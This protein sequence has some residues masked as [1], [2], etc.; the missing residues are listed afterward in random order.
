MQFTIFYNIVLPTYPHTLCF[1]N[2]IVIAI[3]RQKLVIQNINYYFITYFCIINCVW[4]ID[5]S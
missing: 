3:R 4:C 5:V 2:N 1:C